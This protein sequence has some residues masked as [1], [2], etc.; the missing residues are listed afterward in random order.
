[1]PKLNCDILS[2]FHT[3]YHIIS[4]R[5]IDKRC[6]AVAPQPT[7]PE[8]N[9]RLKKNEAFFQALEDSKKFQD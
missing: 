9:G 5:D 8:D 7:I 2:I 3:M 6:A 1:M 4:D